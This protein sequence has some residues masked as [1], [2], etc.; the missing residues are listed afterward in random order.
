MKRI[1]EKEHDAGV[2]VLVGGL[3][4]CIC[5]CQATNAPR[6]APNLEINFESDPPAPLAEV[7]S[8]SPGSDYVWIGG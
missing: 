4:F 2:S 1:H 5:G 3:S 6:L 8:P 7:V